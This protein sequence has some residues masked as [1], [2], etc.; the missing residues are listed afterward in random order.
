MSN[1][2]SVDQP[3]NTHQILVL[4]D[5]DFVRTQIKMFLK[6]GNYTVDEA[7]DGT[8]AQ[9]WLQTNKADLIIVDV[10]MEPMGG[11]EFMRLLRGHGDTTPVIL[12]TGDQNHDLLEQSNKLGVASV[13][14]KPVKKDRL[15]TMVQRLIARHQHI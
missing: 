7:A 9:T 11:F 2:E 10:Q 4:E 5:N 15:V 3:T 8:A 14:I 1:L 13:L 12:V 6:S